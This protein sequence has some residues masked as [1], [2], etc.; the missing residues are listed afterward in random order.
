MDCATSVTR[1]PTARRGC[2]FVPVCRPLHAAHCHLRP[3]RASSVGSMLVNA[4]WVDPAA[5][6]CGPQ[7]V[8]VTAAGMD[9]D[10]TATS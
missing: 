5:G 8:A 7:A 10:A 1:P 3:L 6:T 4:I 2:G 9:E